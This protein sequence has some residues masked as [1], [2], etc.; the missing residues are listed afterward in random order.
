[1]TISKHRIDNT[2][3]IELEGRLDI[4]SYNELEEVLRDN[5]SGVT[6]LVFNLEKLEYLSSAGL[7]VLL[8][9]QKTMND[10]GRMVI[11]NTTPLVRSIFEITGMNSV[12][13][14]E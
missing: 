3:T 12:M 9:A 10:Q 4:T 2:L 5:L 1:M 14:L 11:K 7:R 6:D 8:Y 13:T